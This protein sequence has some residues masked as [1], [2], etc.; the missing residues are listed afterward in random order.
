M[1]VLWMSIL[2]LS[3]AYGYQDDTSVLS[4]SQIAARITGL[5]KQGQNSYVE[6]TR[7]VW[8][9]CL[10]SAQGDPAAHKV[11][12]PIA[13]RLRDEDPLSPPAKFAWGFCKA[14][15]TEDTIDP[16][17][18]VKRMNFGRTAMH[19]AL[20]MGSR[21]PAFLI[22]AAMMLMSTGTEVGMC[23]DAMNALTVARRLYGD[24]F[25]AL[26]KQRQ[27][28]WYAAMAKGFDVLSLQE[29]ARDH[30]KSA[31]TIAPETPSGRL[32]TTWLRA[33]GS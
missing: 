27:A 15:E 22:D 10:R 25:A 5:E 30:F 8:T 16:F 18:R 26:P 4:N 14:K 11:A 32:A 12:R 19:D 33:H 23:N 6:R 2:A 24:A 29:L 31:A 1:K 20:T 13:E 17:S 28:D 21:D 7:L 9:L 3:S